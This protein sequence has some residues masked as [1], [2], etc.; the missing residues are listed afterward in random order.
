MDGAL[1]SKLVHV[2]AAIW[3]VG[4]MVGRLVAHRA[5]QRATGIETMQAMLGLVE[6]FDARMVIPASSLLLIF[7][8]LTAWLQGWPILGFLQGGAVNWVLASL[9]LT[10][11]ILPVVAFV[12]SPR[13]SRRARLLEEAVAAGRVT[14]ELTSAL[15]DRALFAARLYESAVVAVVTALMVLKPF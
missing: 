4:G 8:L 9:L 5:A 6:F 1:W 12:L 14:P 7:G 10:L 11:S 13:R 15:D 2:V 3:M